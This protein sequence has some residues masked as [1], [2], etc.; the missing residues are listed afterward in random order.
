MKT[1][2]KY[3]YCSAWLGWVSN[4]EPLGSQFRVFAVTSQGLSWILVHIISLFDVIIFKNNI[5][6]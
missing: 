2:Y 5:L 6:L 4:Q 3:K 1:K